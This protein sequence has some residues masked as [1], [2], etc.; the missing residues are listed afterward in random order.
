[1][2]YQELR[3][4]L[5]PAGGV[6]TVARNTLDAGVTRLLDDCYQGQSLQ[7]TSVEPGPGDGVGETVVLKGR[8]S[9]LQVPDLPVTARFSLDTEGKVRA[10]LQYELRNGTPG[11][12][13]WTFSRSFPKLPGEVQQTNLFPTEGET[14]ALKPYVDALELF[15]TSYAVTTHAGQD[16]VL[17]VPLEPGINF[18]S[19]LR[20]QGMV[21]VLE[22]AMKGDQVPRIYGPVRIPKPTDVTQPLGLLQRPWDRP[23]A[24]G[25]QLKAP[26]DLDFT[27]GKVA[28]DQAALRIYSPTS[29]DWLN[30][31]PTF[32]A[33]HG[34]SGR[35]A[36]PSAG[37]EL[38]LSA[39]VEWGSPRTFLFAKCQGI[40]LRKLA[41]LV[42]LVGDADLL[43]ALPKELQS[44]VDKLEQLEL[45]EVGL[46]LDVLGTKPRVREILVTVGMP[47]LDWKVWD[48]HLKVEDISCRFR[49]RSAATAPGARATTKVGVTVMG[50]LEIEGTP[51]FV[52]AS[53]D[54]GYSLYAMTEGAVKIPL[55]GLLKK[56][57]PD[58]PPPSELTVSSLAVS[59]APG[60]A[61]SMFMS[62][63]GAPN[64]WVIPCG[65]S[66][67]TLSDVKM[68]FTSP[69]NGKASGAISAT[70]ALGKSLSL[71]VRAATPGNLVLRGSFA[72]IRLRQLIEELCEQA[73][74]LP[75]DFD[76]TFDLATVLIEKR[77]SDYV[78]QVAAELAGVGTFAFEVRRVNGSW[79]FA[80][81]LSL[82]G[83][84]PGKLPGL[85]A[86]SAIEKAIGLQRFMLVFSSFNDAQF[87]FPDM[88]RFNA[89]TLPTQRLSL[90]A[91]A[92][93]V[94]AGMNVFAQ[95]AIDGND[96]QQKLLSGLLGLKGTQDVTIQV[97]QNPA[98]NTRLFTSG[99]CSIQGMPLS[100]Q[101]GLQLANGQTSFFLTGSLVAKIQGQPQT[102]D[103][104]TVFVPGGALMSATMK[105]AT[106]VDCGPF[107][108]SNLAL[109][110]GVNPVGLP[111]LGIAAT[112]DV[113]NFESSVAMF[114]DST[115]P[116]RSLVAGSISDLTA[117]DVLDTLV[118]GNLKTPVDDV[119]KGIAIKG[120]HQFTLPG[121]GPEDLTDELDGLDFAKVAAAFAAAKLTIP[122]SSQ[123]LHLVTNKRGEAWHLTDLT[124]MRHYQLKKRDG[125]IQGSISPQFYFAPAPT[126]IGTIKFPQAFYL[127]AAISFAGFDAQATIDILPNKGFSIEAQMDKMT[128]LDD[129]LFSIRALQGDGGPKISVST[130]NQPENPVKEFQL[131][132]FYVNGSLTMLGVKQGIYANVTVHGIEFELVGNLVPGVHFD[133]AARFGKSGIGANGKVK[134]GVGTI[135][136]G[137]LGKAK[138]NTDLEVVV[139]VDIDNPARTVSA[140]MNTS[141]PKGATVL[142]NEIATLV[143]QGD[144]NLVLYKTT[145][146]SWVPIWASNTNGRN[147][148]RVVFQG[149]GNF[150]M[151][152]GK[153]APVWATGSNGATRVSL[154]GDGNLAI[155]DGAGQMRWNTGT[156]HVEGPS[157]ELESSFQFAG[158]HIDLGKFK[159]EVKG[160]TF[161][162]LGKTVEKKVEQALRD[163]FNDVNK[164]ANAVADGFMDGV[165]D[166]EKVL[167]DVYKKSEQEAKA[168]A[169][170]MNKGVNQAVNAVANTAQDVG[171][172]VNKAANTVANTAQ[173]VGKDVNKGVNQAT[174]AVSNTAKSAE[175][176]AK[177]TVKK[178]KFW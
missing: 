130:F 150:V 89:P 85:G 163:M 82:S 20:P 74:A 158:Q 18:V 76:L 142:Q 132:H 94:I 162:Q 97:G 109:Q 49:I 1:M 64:P 84:S 145:G 117:K 87:A 86:L 103:L 55:S 50:T 140:G 30:Q 100:Y 125:K 13:P 177:K 78:A 148:D 143:F 27:V 168:I 5:V 56:Y 96:K 161:T 75:P 41:Q 77:E 32:Y 8:A 42:D 118:G 110:I 128:I 111:S 153:G 137:P 159:V 175:K 178:M 152:D 47:H 31:N 3:N 139:D 135:D 106:A 6:L 35:L 98:A 88:A 133:L 68:N 10:L 12:N 127:N 4:A 19:K 66:N 115:D 63:A 51:L 122:S 121:S 173:D 54:E 15:D 147:G 70:A 26:L 44:A 156:A 108:L 37:I 105:G 73:G 164:W 123:D 114:F 138:I 7:I 65:R 61:Y 113:K 136:L 104:L 124:K 46:K 11:P 62:L 92:S 45:L 43:S 151:Y 160:D 53:N 22:Y 102:F 39:D 146:T 126:F 90:P 149:D 170:S 17:G 81:G 16:P 60:T 171:K 172:D 176:T 72:D 71:S 141:W 165:N 83:G 59:I 67:I 14:P 144:S 119:L 154:Q 48:D 95:W 169:K 33:R 38:M 157:V 93:G 69:K 131:P 167:R 57:A 40:T 2:N 174:K 52:S 79:G 134:A 23:E 107:K 9:F 91:G 25:I 34:Y 116:S 29:P 36:I 120:T 166:T 28:F 99:R 21:G 101:V 80:G 112:I 129:N 24:P 155:Y 58:L